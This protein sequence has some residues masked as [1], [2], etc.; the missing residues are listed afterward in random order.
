MFSNAAS[1]YQGSELPNRPGASMYGQTLSSNGPS[2]F[3]N[4]TAQPAGFQSSV[5]SSQN[6][7]YGGSGQPQA[8]TNSQQAASS[9]ATGLPQ[10][11]RQLPALTSARTGL[12]S[13]QM[14]Q[15]FTGVGPARPSSDSTTATAV[16]IPKIR[17]SFLAAQ[18]QAKFEQLFKSAVGEGQ[19]LSGI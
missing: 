8:Y 7:G 13:S 14:A 16:K 3:S 6:P 5:T 4:L 10:F 11:E 18:D 12:T 15:S 17:L 19:A 1:S 2:N 9:H